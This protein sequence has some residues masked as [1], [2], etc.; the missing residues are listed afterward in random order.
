M[1]KELAQALLPF[2]NTGEFRRFTETWCNSEIERLRMQLERAKEH[3]EVISLQAEIRTLR[4][5]MA[6]NEHVQ[7]VIRGG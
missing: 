2:T 1:N 4:R 6:L 3:S 5:L 7:A